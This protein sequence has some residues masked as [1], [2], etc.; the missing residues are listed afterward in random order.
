[1]SEK[2]VIEKAS[3]A[4]EDY[5]SVRDP[6]ETQQALSELPQTAV[7]AVILKVLTAIMKQSE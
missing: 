3:R 7:G 5:L 2:M 4:V 6:A 1:M